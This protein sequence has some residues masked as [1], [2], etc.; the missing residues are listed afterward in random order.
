MQWIL[1]MMSALPGTMV[2]AL[3]SIA[4]VVLMVALARFSS[5]YAKWAFVTAYER[6]YNQDGTGYVYVFEELGKEF[7]VEGARINNLYSFTRFGVC[8]R[9]FKLLAI[10]G[11]NVYVKP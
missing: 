11:L 6:D 7:R 4:S 8:E 10:E 5:V 1:D 3:S 9:L 2:I